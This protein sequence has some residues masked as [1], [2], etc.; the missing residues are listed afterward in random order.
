MPSFAVPADSARFRTHCALVVLAALAGLW[1]IRGGSADV[2]EPPQ[3]TSAEAFAPGRADL[4][5]ERSDDRTDGRAAPA[6]LPPSEPVRL[7]IPQIRVDTPMMRLGLDAAGGLDVP[8]EDN[9][10]IAGWY[11]GG[12]PPGAP[13][14]AVVAGHVD[15]AEGPA[16][17][18]HLGALRKG[19]TV[20][21]VRKDGRT[22]VFSIDAI[23][24]YD[25]KNFPERKVYG[26][27]PR[28]ELRVITC[29]G[30]FVEGKGYRGNVVAY[31]HLTHVK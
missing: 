21:V 13:G 22:A 17:F 7:R 31:A 2:G 5:G 11:Q 6:P 23:E 3:P 15:T 1:L 16:V 24:V 26:R 4:T 8:P 14:T 18:Y 30:G 12:T 27:A 28:P 25:K 20:E 10:N 9:P 29:G 19:H